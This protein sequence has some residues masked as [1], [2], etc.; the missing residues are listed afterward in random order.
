MYEKCHPY[1]LQEEV[2]GVRKIDDYNIFINI[3]HLIIF[4]FVIHSIS[5]IL[6]NDRLCY[7]TSY[8]SLL[9]RRWNCLMLL[10]SFSQMWYLPASRQIHTLYEKIMI[11]DIVEHEGEES[12]IFSIRKNVERDK[13]IMCKND[14]IIK[15]R[16][17]LFINI[18]S[19]DE[20]P[21]PFLNCLPLWIN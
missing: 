13:R 20:L 5:K 11:F 16:W 10:L 12:K 17:I 1:G 3:F 21:L 15:F 14:D 18:L 8:C 9:T 2:N 7:S 19:D 4:T 6:S